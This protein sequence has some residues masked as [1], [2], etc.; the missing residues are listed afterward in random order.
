M[1]I[2]AVF[3][4]ISIKHA[5]LKEVEAVSDSAGVRGRRFRTVPN[6]RFSA[7]GPPSLHFC[8]QHVRPPHQGNRSCQQEARQGRGAGTESGVREGLS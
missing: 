1:V 2:E 3:E 7:G 5:V 6:S 8:Q 4:D